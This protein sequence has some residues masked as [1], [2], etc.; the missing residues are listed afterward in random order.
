MSRPPE[1][2]DTARM[3]IERVP[4]QSLE[5]EVSVLGAM[6][7]N[8]EAAKNAA[9]LLTADCFYRTQHY[10]IFSAMRELLAQ[11]EP[12]DLTTVA[13]ILAE[14]G[15]LEKIGGRAALAK[16]ADDVATAAHIEYHCKILVEKAARRRLIH[17]GT[18]LV[19]RCYDERWS[20]EELV[21]EITPKL[22]LPTG[23]KPDDL[24]W[25]GG[26]YMRWT[27]A[28]PDWIVE[29]FLCSQD[30][31]IMNSPGS[32]GKTW[33]LAQLALAAATGTHWL[34]R[35]EAKKCK[36]L[37]AEF[38]R[39]A[40]GNMLRRRLRKI[41][42]GMDIDFNDTNL[43]SNLAITT[44]YHMPHAINLLKGDNVQQFKEIAKS[45]EAQ[46]IIIEV[47]VKIHHAE[48]END[49]GQMSIVMER[50]REIAADTNTAIIVS[51]HD[52]KGI[53]GT[54]GD[55]ATYRGSTVIHDSADAR[56]ELKKEKAGIIRVIHAKPRDT[57]QLE[58]FAVSISDTPEGD[59]VLVQVEDD[60]KLMANKK[61][62]TRAWLLHGLWDTDEAK[63][64]EQVA[65]GRILQKVI[66]R[67]CVEANIASDKIIRDCLSELKAEGIMDWTEGT[68]F[69][70]RKCDHFWGLTI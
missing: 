8:S 13:N 11:E 14:Q 6:L 65:E 51:H 50:L 52:R 45:F 10:T 38:D 15:K 47:L 66:I 64:A 25:K 1:P 26:K 36:V 2:P 23:G 29:P 67:L 59:A 22:I 42:A 27:D 39:H 28:K 70:K 32:T 43:D 68:K 48:N 46:L 54:N 31:V 7:I 21:K 5:T 63:L 58:D 24:L 61:Q 55:G 53:P 69:G 35:F 17:A 20:N 60:D 57:K 56:I 49:A 4:P 16:L 34:G 3:V 30:V 37:Y 12:V 44:R 41:A 40:D 33:L 62:V 19:E 9:E 18:E